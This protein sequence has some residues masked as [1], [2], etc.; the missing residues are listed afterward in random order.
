MLYL[1]NSL[2]GQW[3]T[4]CFHC[5]RDRFHPWLRNK[6]LQVVQPRMEI[7]SLLEYIQSVKF[8]KIS[9][10][11]F[12]EDCWQNQNP[13]PVD[14]TLDIIFKCLLPCLMLT[15][16]QMRYDTHYNAGGAALV[17]KVI[18]SPPAMWETWVQS[19][20]QED[21]PGEEMATHHSILAWRIPWTEE[22]GGL[23]SMGSQRDG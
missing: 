22:P 6:I 12:S 11:V 7:L 23:Q 15:S 16:D 3:L 10:T 13:I 1:G 19:L 17:I 8:L 2:V 4:P 21:P 20:N 5:S 14:T 9:L 18:K